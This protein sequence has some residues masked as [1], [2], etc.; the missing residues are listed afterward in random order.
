MC[1]IGERIR[2]GEFPA[3]LYS[4]GTELSK[5]MQN[6]LEDAG[7]NYAVLD[8]TVESMDGPVL[9]V[10]GTFL[11]FDDLKGVLGIQ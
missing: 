2:S 9:I 1:K 6:W 4:D 7:V 8:A 3:I 11:S 10:D 5:S